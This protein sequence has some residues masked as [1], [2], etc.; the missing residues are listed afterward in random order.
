MSEYPLNQAKLKQLMELRVMSD[1]DLARQSG[2]GRTTVYYLRTGKHQTTSERNIKALADALGTTI[3]YLSSDEAID[4]EDGRVAVMLPEAL[5][6]LT[7]IAAR[8]SEIRQ[9]E[10]VRIAAT[11][12]EMERAQASTPPSVKTMEA[13]LL[14]AEQLREQVG[15]TDPLESLEA[16]LRANHTTLLRFSPAGKGVDKPM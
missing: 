16:V 4:E 6:E 9:E 8:L 14:V 15:G 1:G 12:E 7:Q 5:L 10:L 11:L 3:D 2:L 13:L